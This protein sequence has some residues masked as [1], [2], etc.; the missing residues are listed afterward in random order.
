M[1]IQ[2]FTIDISDEI[3]DDMRQR[4]ANT[5]WPDEIPNSDWDYGSNM[6]YVRE[7]ADY[8][9]NEFDWRKQEGDAE[10][11][12]AVQ[13]GCGGDEHPLHP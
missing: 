3:L 4:F 10:R 11:L 12:F 8:W 13:G 2:P 9:L 1:A 5:R 6:A 7:L